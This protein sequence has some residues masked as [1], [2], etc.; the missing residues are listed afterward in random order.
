MTAPRNRWFMR[1][2]V[3]RL[4]AGSAMVLVI[5]AVLCWAKIVYERQN[6]QV[7]AAWSPVLDG[8]IRDRPRIVAL[9]KSR[10]EWNYFDEMSTKGF[11]MVEFDNSVDR[12]VQMMVCW[13]G[14][15][16]RYIELHCICLSFGPYSRMDFQVCPEDP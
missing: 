16:R 12:V 9:M 6:Y 11:D 1:L 15:R 7:P 2:G 5:L 8:T 13:D 10:P 14:D 4:I 3:M